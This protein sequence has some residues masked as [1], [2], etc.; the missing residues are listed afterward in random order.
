[1]IY[2]FVIKFMVRRL[3][4]PFSYYFRK[5]RISENKENFSQYKFKRTKND[6]T[7]VYSVI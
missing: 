3:K 6:Y 1:M 4:L 7:L 2:L 5:Y